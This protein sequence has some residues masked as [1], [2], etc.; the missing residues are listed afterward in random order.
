MWTDFCLKFYMTNKTLGRD[1]DRDKNLTY[2]PQDESGDVPNESF[3][4][5]DVKEKKTI[6]SLIVEQ[7]N[8]IRELTFALQKSN[9]EIE[10]QKLLLDLI[11]LWMIHARAEEN[12]LYEEPLFTL[13]IQQ[14]M[15]SAI[16][17]HE[18]INFLI[19]E[20]EGLNFRLAWSFAIDLKAKAL[21]EMINTHLQNEEIS[22]A[23][24]ELAFLKE[25]LLRLGREFTRQFE[26][27]ASH[28]KA[29]LKPSQILT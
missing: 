20:V 8:Q 14:R 6:G 26:A 19:D 24:I 25:D 28:N 17:E 3:A 5:F 10:K 16:R 27:A 15:G 7:H 29:S 2:R 12:T 22:L 9:S 21:A 18:I 4:V 13:E 1:F 11:S 23:M